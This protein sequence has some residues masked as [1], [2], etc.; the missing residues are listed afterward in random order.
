M[1]RRVSATK[2]SRAEAPRPD[3]ALPLKRLY[4]LRHAKSGW[5]DE[6]IDDHDRPL[7]KRGLRDAGSL[8]SYLVQSDAAFDLVLC[9]SALRTR[10][11]LDALLMRLKPHRVIIDHDLYLASSKTVLDHVRALNDKDRSVLVIAHNPGLHELALALADPQSAPNLPSLSGK[12][13]TGALAGFAIAGSWRALA[14]RSAQLLSYVTP[15]D[16]HAK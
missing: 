4:L 16:L 11:T 10:Q 8:A 15:H 1:A 7:A 3:E 13:P 2:T 9:S 5:D 14:L 12:F 6:G